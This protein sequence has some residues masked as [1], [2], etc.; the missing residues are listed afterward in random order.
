MSS[1]AAAAATAAAAASPAAA[2][3]AEA[4]SR[5]GELRQRERQQDDAAEALRAAI[6]ALRP[7]RVKDDKRRDLDA[8]ERALTAIRAAIRE[9]E[10]RI[11]AAR[12]VG[13]GGDPA[14]MAA[15][16][17]RL[18]ALREQ[19]QQ[20]ARLAM[21]MRMGE[22]TF[23]ILDEEDEDVSVGVAFAITRHHLLTAKHNVEIRN[24]NG[25]LVRRLSSVRV[26][27]AFQ[28][29]PAAPA[30]AVASSSSSSAAAASGASNVLT[31]TVIGAGERLDYAVLIVECI[32]PPVALWRGAFNMFHAGEAVTLFDLSIG[33]VTEAK[34]LTP[35]Y[36]LQVGNI[37]SVHP[38]VFHYNAQTFPGDSGGPVI[39]NDKGEVCGMHV[40]QINKVPTH[41]RD[42]AAAAADGRKP[43]SA[44][45]RPKRP[46][47]DA[48]EELRSSL[49]GSTAHLGEALRID[50]ILPHLMQLCSG[51]LTQVAAA[52]AK[53]V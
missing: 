41:S 22:A 8:R 27:S 16:F 15:E 43:T 40:Q 7:G 4:Q 5:L 1:S 12:G 21:K 9:E 19:E 6:E 2:T 34:D 24:A 23:G 11:D 32:L 36:S 52:P 47:G 51:E 26:K 45:R 50:V 46:R 49:S 14:A 30:V 39:I 44:E 48:A 31:A 17:T 38:E 20:Q 3:I 28:H 33:A 10:A 37:V 42:A 25:E 53:Q 29:G 18:Q 35:T 13:G